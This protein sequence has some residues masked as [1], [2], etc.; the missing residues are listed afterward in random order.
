MTQLN[1]Q[2][3]TAGERVS[4]PGSGYSS[5][6]NPMPSSTTSGQGTVNEVVLPMGIDSKW[7]RAVCQLPKLVSVNL[8]YTE[9][10]DRTRH[11]K[12]IKSYVET[13]VL[14]YQ[15]T[16]ARVHNLKKYHKAVQYAVAKR[17]EC[18]E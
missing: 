13:F 3:S 11:D 1:D 2:T 5:T 17:E 14:R 18:R 7:G 10:I 6:A 4:N 8:S 15:R 16:S 9:I 12:D